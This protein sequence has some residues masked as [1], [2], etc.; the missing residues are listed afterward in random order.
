MDHKGNPP[1]PVGGSYDPYRAIESRLDDGAKKFLEYTHERCAVVLFNSGRW[2]GRLH[3]PIC[4]I[5]AMFGKM[6]FRVPVGPHAARSTRESSM[7]AGEGG[8]FLDKETG[9]PRHTH[10]GAVVVLHETALGGH[11]ALAELE[12]IHHEEGRDSTDDELREILGKHIRR[13]VRVTVYENPYT[14]VERRIPREVF[15]GEH[16][17]IWGS[18]SRCYVEVCCGGRVAELP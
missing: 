9:E 6:E 14:A 12:R 18:D 8:F 15:A 10:I 4:V 2:L 7:A 1:E 16:D 11:E 13:I 17:V 5:G 3:S